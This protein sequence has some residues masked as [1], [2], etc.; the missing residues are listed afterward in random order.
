M[1]GRHKR[2]LWAFALGAAIAAALPMALELRILAGANGFFA[3]YLGL[4]LRFA[5]GAGADVLRRHAAQEDEGIVFILLLA[6]GSVLVSLTA[7]Y[8]VLNGHGAAGPLPYTLAL[9]GVPLGWAMVHV[10]AA[11]HYA[12]LYYGKGS[13]AQGLIFPGVDAPG[14]WDFLYFAFG[15]GM[16]AQ[17][18]DV[19]TNTSVMRRVVL[20]HAVGSFFYNTVIL[21]LAV[22]AAVTASL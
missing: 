9:V 2:F 5:R 21:A 10:L 6:L 3:C 14:P 8:L 13:A 15:I 7:I 18:S 22:N 16:T 4:M 17:V 12:H 19:T 11:F 20:F 1:M